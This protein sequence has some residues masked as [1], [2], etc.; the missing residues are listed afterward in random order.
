MGSG[1]QLQFPMADHVHTRLKIL[2]EVMESATIMQ[3]RKQY[4][5]PEI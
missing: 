5:Q 2:D 1:K 4:T 3:T